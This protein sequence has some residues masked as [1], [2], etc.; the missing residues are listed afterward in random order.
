MHKSHAKPWRKSVQDRRTITR[1]L[2]Q[3]HSWCVWARAKRPWWSEVCE[4]GRETEEMR[5]KRE[6]G[7]NNR[8][9]PV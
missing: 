3:E 9:Q 6:Q 4:N 5:S 8:L 7:P 2:R 1:V